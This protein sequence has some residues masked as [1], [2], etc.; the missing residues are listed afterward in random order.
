MA[1]KLLAIA[2]ERTLSRKKEE[3]LQGEGEQGEEE[4]KEERIRQ[5]VQ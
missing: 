2:R 1:N 4:S 5:P 3:S